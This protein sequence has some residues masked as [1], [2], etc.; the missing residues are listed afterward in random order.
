MVELTVWKPR[1]KRPVR[2]T[3]R[4]P[5]AYIGFQRMMEPFLN[6]LLDHDDLL[7]KYTGRLNNLENPQA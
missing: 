3:G 7:K 1:C 6:R 5:T 4:I 2:K